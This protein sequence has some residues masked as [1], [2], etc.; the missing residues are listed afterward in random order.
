M[1]LPSH[2]VTAHVHGALDA[3]AA[4]AAAAA[5]AVAAQGW[6]DHQEAYSSALTC[7]RAGSQ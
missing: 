3:A 2:V 6:T 1:L 4:A 7:P 5:V